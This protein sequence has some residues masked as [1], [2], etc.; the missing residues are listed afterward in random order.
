MN[1]VMK[2]TF[3]V[4]LKNPLGQ[5]GSPGAAPVPLKAP[6]TAYTIMPKAFISTTTS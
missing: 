2:G 5:C 4:S 6:K 3:N 1:T